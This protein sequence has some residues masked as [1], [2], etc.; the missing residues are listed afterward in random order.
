MA[1]S[2]PPTAAGWRAAFAVAAL[3]LV[4]GVVVPALVIDA[5]AHR[6]PPARAG[7]LPFAAGAAAVLSLA[8]GWL[9]LR[10]RRRRDA[11]PPVTAAAPPAAR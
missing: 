1:A 2:R 5:A 10:E 8:I 3:L 6:L 4:V 7:L 11:D 9:T